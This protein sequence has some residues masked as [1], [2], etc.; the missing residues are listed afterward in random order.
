[1]RGAGEEDS[2]A[3][4]SR[5]EYGVLA[6][7]TL[8]GLAFTLPQLTLRCLPLPLGARTEQGRHGRLDYLT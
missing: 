1:M 3:P 7:G 2:T 8:P 5:T 6:V 4:S